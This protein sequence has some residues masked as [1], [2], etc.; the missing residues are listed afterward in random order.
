M[1]KSH[2]LGEVCACV[3]TLVSTLSYAALIDHGG[4]LIYD[5]ILDVTWL[6]D[7]NY[8]KTNG[9]DTDGVMTWVEANTWASNLIYFDSVRNVTYDDWR[10]PSVSPIDGV[11][12]N[13]NV[14]TDGTTDRGTTTTT[15][16]GS[17]GGWRDGSGNPVSEMGHMYYVNLANIGICDPNL[18]W[19][20]W[21]VGWGLINTSPFTNLQSVRYWSGTELDSSLAWAFGFDA[22]A[23]GPNP[24]LD[25][26]YAWAVR[27]GNVPTVIDETAMVADDVVIGDGSSIGE[28]TVIEKGVSVGSN[29]TIATNV[30]I[31]KDTQLSD[32]TVIGDGSM[33]NKDVTAGDNLTV[34]SNVTIHKDVVIGARVTIGDNTEIQAD[35]VI[36][37]DVWIGAGV[38][39]GKSVV[40]SSGQ[41]IGDGEV[42]PNNTTVP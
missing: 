5:D 3:I 28:Y 36:G 34:G 39:I 35:T 4:G 41:V 37:N 26:Y 10:L 7:A 8:A 23:Q 14:S 31:N 13:N 40:I 11:S 32:N 25:N 19:C 27:D 16:D 29:S 2:M 30:A 33:I 17:D 12:F 15:T 42:I 22:G 6:Q 1:K 9:Y 24:K 38:F 18:P 21:Q 20:T